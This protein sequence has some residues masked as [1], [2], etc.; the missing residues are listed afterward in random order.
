MEQVELR[1]DPAVVVRPRLLEPLEVCV[2]V[3]LGEERGAVDPGELRVLLVAAP[4][5][6]REPRQLDRLDRQESW[7]CGPRQR[8]VKS[9]CV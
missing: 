3:G 5:R 7:R 8:S 1:A 6:A 9:P 2:E 4:V